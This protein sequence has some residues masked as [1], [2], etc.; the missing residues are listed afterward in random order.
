MKRGKRRKRKRKRRRKERK[1]VKSRCSVAASSG[2]EKPP[3]PVRM[4]WPSFEFGFSTA[5]H[6]RLLFVLLSSGLSSLWRLSLTRSRT[7]LLG[8]S[9]RFSGDSFPPDL[10]RPIFFISIPLCAVFISLRVVHAF[11]A[12]FAPDPPPIL[13]L[14]GLHQ[15]ALC[16]AFHLAFL[17]FLPRHSSALIILLVSTQFCESDSYYVNEFQFWETCPIMQMLSSDP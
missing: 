16:A 11:P 17:L 3:P 15:P 10:L 1:K 6:Q 9:R 14:I 13:P 4:T 5:V 12:T 7:A 8:L 2:R